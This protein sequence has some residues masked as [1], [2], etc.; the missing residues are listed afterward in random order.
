[1]PQNMARLEE[2]VDALT[3]LVAKLSAQLTAADKPPVEDFIGTESACEILHL[4]S[5]R[6][7]AL[8]Q[9]GRI[10]FYKPG[11]SLL[12]LKIRVARLAQTVSPKR[13]AVHRRTDGSHDKRYAQ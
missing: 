10:P 13:S 6:I 7:Y 5:S 3:E 9:E 12:F 2:K 8:V 1:M 4:S 11:K